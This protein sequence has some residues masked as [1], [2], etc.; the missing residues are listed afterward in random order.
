MD[1]SQIE[2]FITRY[3]DYGYSLFNVSVIYHDDDLI[4]IFIK[5]NDFKTLRKSNC[6][7]LLPI[8]RIGMWNKTH[9]LKCTEIVP[10]RYIQSID[11]LK[12]ITPGIS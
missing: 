3:T 2:Y 1:S 4:G 10:G 7:R 9:D 12:I 5:G 11:L 6:W 8:E